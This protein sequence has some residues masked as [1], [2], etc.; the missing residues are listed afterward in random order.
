MYG[1]GTRTA[2]GIRSPPASSERV[3][4]GARAEQTERGRVRRSLCSARSQPAAGPVKL[5]I[6]KAMAAA[7]PKTL[8]ELAALAQM[9]ESLF[10]EFEPSDFEDLTKDLGLPVPVRVRLRSQFRE[11]RAAAVVV[12]AQAKFQQFLQRA[13]GHP[14]ALL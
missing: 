10:A 8:A 11:L 7:A 12:T 4:W 1:P 9:E 6:E 5:H 13:S 3:V 14:T 2:T